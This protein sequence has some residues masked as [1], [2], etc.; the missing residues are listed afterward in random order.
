VL[1]KIPDRLGATRFQT[2]FDLHCGIASRVTPL[3]DEPGALSPWQKRNFLPLP[4]GQG[5]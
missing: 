2:V 4:H 5:W 1:T 3:N